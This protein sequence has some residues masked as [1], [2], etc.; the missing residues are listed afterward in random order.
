MHRTAITVCLLAFTAQP[1]LAQ[2]TIEIEY[3]G[4]AVINLHNFELGEGTTAQQFDNR[5]VETGTGGD[6]VGVISSGEC[7][8]SAEVTANSYTDTMLCVSR[9]TETD[10]VVSRMQFNTDGWDWT[11]VGGTGKF[12][13]ATG[14]GRLVSVWGDPKFGDRLTYTSKGT[15]TLK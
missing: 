2:T 7:Y 13:G 4:V 15:I 6:V 11:V 5:F 10:S 14:T 3:Q 1:A 8:G 12:A 9:Q